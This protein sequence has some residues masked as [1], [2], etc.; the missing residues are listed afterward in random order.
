[1]ADSTESNPVTTEQLARMSD[2]ELVESLRLVG[3]RL[4][5]SVGTSL[6]SR[7][8]QAAT[9]I[10][11]ELDRRLPDA[12]D[13]VAEQVVTAASQLPPAAANENIPS[14]VV[15]AVVA[16]PEKST[17]L[18]AGVGAALGYVAARMLKR[19]AGLL[20]GLGA[21]AGAILKPIRRA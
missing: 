5:Q 15:P 1:M 12:G 10:S 6:K 8:Y 9:D 11:D 17:L 20:V 21:V 7:L 16:A 14:T 19:P 18:N 13:N 3:G 4:A 2:A